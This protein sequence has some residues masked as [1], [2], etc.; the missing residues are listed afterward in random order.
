MDSSEDN[1]TSISDSSTPVVQFSS[2]TF[3]ALVTDSND[4]Q[5]QP[6]Y[7]VDFHFVQAPHLIFKSEDD[8]STMGSGTLHVI[9]INPD[10][11]IRGVK[12]TLTAQKRLKT[13]YTHNSHVFS[14]TDA[15]MTMTWTSNTSLKVWDFVCVDVQQMPVA[16]LSYNNWALKN[17]GKFEFLGPRANTASAKDEL[18]VTG[19][20]L[21]YCMCLRINNP[22]NLVGS[23]TS[24]PGQ[25]SE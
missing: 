5:A 22:F 14:D 16:K 18:V 11:E 20:T 2:S 13:E 21:F 4:P 12:G 6:I 9:S 7:K 23:F 1:V 3:K 25:H 15:P 17:M 19:L 24:R 8:D 10:Y